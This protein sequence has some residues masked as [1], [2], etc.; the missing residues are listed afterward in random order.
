MNDKRNLL[1]CKT[2]RLVFMCV[3]VSV[4]KNNNVLASTHTNCCINTHICVCVPCR[5]ARSTVDNKHT[6]NIHFCHA[7]VF[8][9]VCACASVVTYTL[10][11]NDLLAPLLTKKFVL[12]NVSVY[13]ISISI[14]QLLKNIFLYIHLCELIFLSETICARVCVWSWLLRICVCVRACVSAAEMN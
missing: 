13:V 6:N 7:I 8:M 12:L 3:C 10:C 9:F 11:Y 14:Y 4:T 2:C 5:H 1:L